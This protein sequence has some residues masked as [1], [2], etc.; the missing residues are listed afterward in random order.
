M[1]AAFARPFIGGMERMTVPSRPNLPIRSQVAEPAILPDRPQRLNPYSPLASDR[2]LPARPNVA[3]SATYFD[4]P[5]KCAVQ[6]KPAALRFRR[7]EVNPKQFLIWQT[8]WGAALS[9]SHADESRARAFDDKGIVFDD[10]QCPHC[11]TPGG[12]LYCFTCRSLICRGAVTEQE[13]GIAVK[14]PCGAMG[15]LTVYRTEVETVY[16]ERI[17]VGH[18]EPVMRTRRYSEPGTGNFF[19]CCDRCGAGKRTANW[20]RP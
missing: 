19:D 18:I 20:R 10:V 2:N 14:C 8:L 9:A 12:T 17:C 4:L 11:A 6:D 15:F 7:S 16:R 5:M 3:V 13:N 1:R